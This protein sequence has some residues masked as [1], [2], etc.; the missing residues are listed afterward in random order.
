MSV[1]RILR[2]ITRH[3]LNQN[4]KIRALLRFAKWQIGSRLVPGDVLFEWVNGAKLVVRPGETAATG[5]IYA[6]LFEFSDMAYVIHVLRED[7]LFIDVGANIGSFTVLAGAVA[8]A[9]GFSFEPAPSTF[10][11]LAMNIKV[12]RLDDKMQCFNIGLGAQ[13]G[14]IAFTNDE[15]ATNHA[16]SESETSERAIQ[17]D[18]STLDIVLA[19]QSPHVMKIDVEG[20]ETLVLEGAE[21]TLKKESLHSVLIELQGHGKRYGFDESKI[22]DMMAKLGFEMFS[23]DPVNRSLLNLQGEKPESG[24]VLFIRNHEAASQAVRDSKEFEVHGQR[25]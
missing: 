13:Q 22:F 3:P 5:N 15:G 12:N 14:T 18:V 8:G 25:F 2:F 6:G 4:G 21:E 20:Y 17:V 7:D 11:K 1:A 9:R 10:K 19:D 16:L 23:Y 24:N